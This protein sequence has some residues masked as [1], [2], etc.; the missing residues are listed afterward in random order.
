MCKSVVS[1]QCSIIKRTIKQNK[2]NKKTMQEKENKDFIFRL[3]I[4]ELQKEIKELKEE[5]K[6]LNWMLKKQ[7][8]FSMDVIRKET[9]N[10]NK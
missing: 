9:Q 2:L 6:N 8:D 5:N 4:S 3:R 7:F 10:E 1:L